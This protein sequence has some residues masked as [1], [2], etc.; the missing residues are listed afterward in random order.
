VFIDAIMD[1]GQQGNPHAIA[2]ELIAAIDGAR[3]L[4]PDVP[5]GLGWSTRPLAGPQF[6]PRRPLHWRCRRWRCGSRQ[7]FRW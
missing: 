7:R 2:A 4:S 6:V 3:I 1:Y 5:G